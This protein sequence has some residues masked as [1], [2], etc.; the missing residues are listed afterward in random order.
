MRNDYRIFLFWGTC[1]LFVGFV[2]WAF[3]DFP[4]EERWTAA[5]NVLATVAIGLFTFTLWQSTDKLWTASEKQFGLS[6][7][8]SDR[9]AIE[10]QNQLDLARISARAA[11]Q[12][13]KAAIAA[14]RARFFIIIIKHNLNDVLATIGMYP[15]SPTMP[16]R[17]EPRIEYVFKN[18][19][20]TPGII[21]EVSH[22][23]VVHPGPPEPV[24]AVSGHLFVENMIAAGEGTENQT[25]DGPILFDSIADGLPILVGQKHIWFYGR[26]D[27]EDVFGN[28]QVHRWSM[29]YVKIGRSWFFQPYDYK[30]YN[31]SS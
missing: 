5:I 17:F 14:E 13:A 20:K 22:G 12:S 7:D 15:N 11:E 26:F 18:Y 9:Q 4:L 27:Y 30:H 24:Y 8:I 16:L 25:F 21:N 6:K 28:P 31:S 10:I 2:W 29:R 1:A 23:L 19:G 3:F